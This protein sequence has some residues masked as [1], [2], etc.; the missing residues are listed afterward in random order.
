MSAGPYLYDDGPEPLHT[1]TPRRRPVLLLAIFGGTTILAILMV[2]ALPLIKGSPANQAKQAVGVFLAALKNGDT[3]T[4]HELLCAKEQARLKAADVPG[5]YT[6]SATGTVIGVSDDADGRTQQ[7]SVH[8]S[9]GSTSRI[10]VVPEGG[11][12]VCG[13][14]RAG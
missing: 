3:A 1:G 9:D 7:V 8:W 2:L 11:A 10:A 12:H 13:I 5:A 6:G 14:D 4:A